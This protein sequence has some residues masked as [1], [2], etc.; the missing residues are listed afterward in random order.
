MILFKNGQIAKKLVGAQPRS[1]IE[2][3]LEPVLA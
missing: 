2:S 1:R 3:E